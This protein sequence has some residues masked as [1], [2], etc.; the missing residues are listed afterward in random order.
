MKPSKSE[1]RIV[2]IP[3]TQHYDRLVY[4]MPQFFNAVCIVER[5]C[6]PHT[7]QKSKKIERAKYI[8]NSVLN[9]EFS[10]SF[11]G[12]SFLGLDL[13][14]YS[15][16]KPEIHFICKFQ[17]SQQLLIVSFSF[18]TRLISQNLSFEPFFQFSG[19]AA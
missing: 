19:S 4:F 17:F 15:G 5:P 2:R 10:L 11:V 16:F 9:L 3:Y 13:N 14:I 1:K 18:S 8:P 7:L 12:F 6:L